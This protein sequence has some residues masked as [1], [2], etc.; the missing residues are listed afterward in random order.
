L[1]SDIADNNI[2]HELCQFNMSAD[3]ISH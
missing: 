3:I 1:L 2:P